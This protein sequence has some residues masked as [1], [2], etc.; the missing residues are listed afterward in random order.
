MSAF[1]VGKPVEV[2]IDGL[3][4]PLKGTV[5]R[6]VPSADPATRSYQIKI[7]LPEQAGLTPGM[8]GRA[9]FQIGESK[10][11]VVPRTALVERGG[12]SGVFVVDS[13]NTAHFRWIGLK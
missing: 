10:S 2:R 6:F 11:P 1:A 4:A 3:S 12:L 8:F 9:A 13:E 7:A 5:S